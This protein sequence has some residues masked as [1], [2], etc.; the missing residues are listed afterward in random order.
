MQAPSLRFVCWF[1]LTGAVK[2]FIRCCSSSLPFLSPG[3]WVR[4]QGEKG[5]WGEGHRHRL[6]LGTV[7]SFVM[8]EP[9]FMTYSW[10]GG[11]GGLGGSWQQL[12]AVGVSNLGPIR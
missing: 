1:T 5:E 11:F 8:W 12:G 6:L 7:R 4:W 10:R 2:I 3:S 9:H